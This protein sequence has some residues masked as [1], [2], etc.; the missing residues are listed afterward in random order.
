MYGTTTKRYLPISHCGARSSRA[1]FRISWQCW[2]RCVHC[3]TT[4]EEFVAQVGAPLH[5]SESDRANR[6]RREHDC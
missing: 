5:E 6:L 3:A 1:R 4:P 2:K